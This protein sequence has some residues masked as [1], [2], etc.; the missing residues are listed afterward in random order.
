VALTVSFTVGDARHVTLSR[1]FDSSPLTFL[2]SFQMKRTEQK[3]PN[4]LNLVRFSEDRM[5]RPA[6]SAGSRAPVALRQFQYALS[7]LPRLSNHLCCELNAC[8]SPRAPPLMDP[9]QFS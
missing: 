3:A 9:P 4:D 1:F 5:S 7:P 6:T 2:A 8:E